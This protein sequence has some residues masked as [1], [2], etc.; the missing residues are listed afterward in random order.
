VAILLIS[1][2]FRLQDPSKKLAVIILM[3]SSGVALAS[4]GELRFN[5]LGFLTQ[6][7]AVAVSLFFTIQFPFQYIPT[8]ND[9]Y[10]SSFLPLII[11]DQKV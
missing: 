7:A 8:I 10:N 9:A 6:T 11:S 2:T 5:L 4:H 1:W 3:I